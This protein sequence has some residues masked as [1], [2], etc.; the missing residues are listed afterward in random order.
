MI[1]GLITAF[2][3]T[4]GAGAAYAEA[5]LF[6]GAWEVKWCD[7]NPKI[8]CGGFYLYLI[9]KGTRICGDHFAATPGLGRLNEGGPKSIIGTVV[10]STAV[11]AITSGRD[12]TTYL[13]KA[14]RVGPALEWQLLETIKE[15]EKTDSSLIAANARLSASKDREELNRVTKECQEVFA[16][17]RSGR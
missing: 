2:L 16:N 11:V 15:G 12:N 8:E 7:K 13:A 17:D 10:G 3:L 4:F 1:R 6:S 14:K 5:H 9:Q